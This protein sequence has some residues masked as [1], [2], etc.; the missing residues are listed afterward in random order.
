MLVVPRTC[1][2]L[3]GAHD[4]TRSALRCI[5]SPSSSHSYGCPV[6]DWTGPDRTANNAP[7]AIHDRLRTAFSVTRPLLKS[8]TIEQRNMPCLLWLGLWLTSTNNRQ[9]PTL[10]ASYH[11]IDTARYLH[12]LAA[13]HQGRLHA[14]D[15]WLSTSDD[16]LTTHCLLGPSI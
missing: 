4:T 9:P 13:S 15:S 1:C 6:L 11:F 5:A 8:A 2:L 16:A 10:A 12:C 3:P 7:N 14:I